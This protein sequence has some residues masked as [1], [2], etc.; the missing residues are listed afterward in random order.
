MTAL[1]HPAPMARPSLPRLTAVELRKMT[2]TRAGFWLLCLVVLGAVA[3]VVITLAAGHDSEHTLRRFFILSGV[4]ASILLPVVGI[5]AVTGEWTQR[6]A[7]TTFTLVPERGRVAAAKL[8]AGC[9]LALAAVVACLLVAVVGNAVAG[10]QWNLDAARLAGGTAYMLIS[11]LGGLALGL[12]L[13][14][15][16]PAIV[17]YFVVPTAVGILIQ[18]VPSLH[19][20]SQW[21]D[22]GQATAPLGDG[23]LAGGDWPRLAVAVAIWIGLPLILG[24]V[25]LRRRELS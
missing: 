10:G 24:L 15:S 8:L 11:M 21:F 25:R 9:G 4:T 23:S 12:L 16:A 20:P 7:L 3:A 17:T 19:G 5:L 14:S 18:A 6:T 1:A 22:L 13:M 2:D